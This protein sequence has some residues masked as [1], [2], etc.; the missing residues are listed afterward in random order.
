MHDCMTATVSIGLD[1]H[2]RLVHLTALRAGE[3]ARA[4]FV[5]ERSRDGGAGACSLAGGSLLL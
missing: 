3:L 5:A 1:V 4:A 2:A